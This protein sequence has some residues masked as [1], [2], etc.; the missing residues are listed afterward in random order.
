MGAKHTPGPWLVYADL[1]SVEPDWHIVTNA[2]RQRVLANVHIQPGNT[3]DEANARLIAAA[4][5]M[6]AALQYL[7]T[8]HGEQLHDAFD[9]AQR[10]VA[11]ASAS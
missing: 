2:S 5:D 7:L 11:K 10:A 9:Q 6:L 3:V 4:P 8:A 1:P